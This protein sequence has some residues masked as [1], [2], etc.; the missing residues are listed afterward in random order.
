MIKE[1]VAVAAV[2]YVRTVRMIV[3][4]CAFF[5]LPVTVEKKMIAV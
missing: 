1:I 4:L 5:V 2:A 3:S